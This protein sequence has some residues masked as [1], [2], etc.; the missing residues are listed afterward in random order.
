MYDPGTDGLHVVGN[1]VTYSITGTFISVMVVGCSA[2]T[3]QFT[4]CQ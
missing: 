2:R 1:E 3:C 4:S